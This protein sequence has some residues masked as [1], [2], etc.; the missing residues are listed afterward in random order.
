MLQTLSPIILK[1]FRFATVGASGL[2]IDFGLT[3]IIKEKL[4]ANKYLANTVGF[5]AAATSN[6][7]INRTWT[8]SNSDPNVG[9]QFLKFILFSLVGLLIN[10]AIVWLMNDR[11]KKNFYTSKAMATAIVTI[12]NFLSNFLFTFR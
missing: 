9:G 6:F 11:F 1:F 3:Y 5:F 4:K 7:F 8:F 10:S 2:I 12:W